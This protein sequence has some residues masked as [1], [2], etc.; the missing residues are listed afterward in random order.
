MQP[1][2]NNASD[3]E[4]AVFNAV[5]QLA[6]EARAAYLDQACAG[7]HAVRLRLEALLKVHDDVSTFLENPTQDSGAAAV[8]PGAG[9][10]IRASVSSIEKPGDR[11]GRY[12]LLQQIGEG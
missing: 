3:R 5:L 8:P 4:V 7:D 6:L 9:G 12:K 2:M 11:I 1:P 10:D